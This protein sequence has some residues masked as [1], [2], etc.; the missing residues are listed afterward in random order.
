MMD[1]LL[2][3]PENIALNKIKS[4]HGLSCTLFMML[5]L[6]LKVFGPVDVLKVLFIELELNS[7][8]CLFDNALF[9]FITLRRY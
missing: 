2:V 3:P 5:K 6:G 9:A 1:V 7:L 4:K 8:L